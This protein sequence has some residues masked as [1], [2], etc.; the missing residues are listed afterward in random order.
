MTRAWRSENPGAILH[1]G[2]KLEVH[3][4]PP[5]RIFVG[6]GKARWFNHVGIRLGFD[7]EGFG[8]GVAY[9]AVS[10]V[11]GLGY[12]VFRSGGHGMGWI[13]GLIV[14][15]RGG[16]GTVCREQRGDVF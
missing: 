6:N 10:E 16:R 11:F 12:V 5:V 1:K 3:G 4:T 9:S 8:D 7:K 13:L 14:C 15:R 2:V